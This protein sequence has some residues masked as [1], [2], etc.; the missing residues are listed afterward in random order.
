ML[1]DPNQQWAIIPRQAAQ[2]LLVTFARVFFVII[3][4]VGVFFFTVNIT[5][6]LSKKRSRKVFY[7][8]GAF[9]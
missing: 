2:D 9:M 8:F 4:F 3:F 7:A 5:R 1:S 6:L